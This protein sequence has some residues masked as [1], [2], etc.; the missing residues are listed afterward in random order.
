MSRAP[1]GQ[2]LPWED[3]KK[4]NRGEW[5]PLPIGLLSRDQDNAGGEPFLDGYLIFML[6]PKIEPGSKQFG[7]ITPLCTNA[8][9][10]T[11]ALEIC[12]AR[13]NRKMMK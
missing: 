13:N 6:D 4:W 8:M 9:S 11:E 10:L 3:S 2:H 7:D 1:Y 5:Y 12:E